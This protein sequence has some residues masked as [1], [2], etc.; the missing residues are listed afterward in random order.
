MPVQTSLSFFMK[1]PYEVI[2]AFGVGKKGR[3]EWTIGRD[4][5]RDAAYAEPDDPQ[6]EGDVIFR[7]LARPFDHR[8]EMHLCPPKQTP[9]TFTAPLYEVR[10]F[11]N[12]TDEISPPGSSLDQDA[13]S[14]GL[15]T[16][17]DE[18]TEE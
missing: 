4:L 2:A 6:G 11:I 18:S 7:R 10:E 14:E 8:L 12:D 13:F 9:A 3:L 17:L 1:N 16:F 15:Q 5:V